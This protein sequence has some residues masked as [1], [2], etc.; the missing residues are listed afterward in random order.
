[1]DEI[2]TWIKKVYEKGYT[3][4]QILL[5][6]KANEEE[7]KE[8]LSAQQINNDWPELT[9]DD[10]RNIVNSYRAL[11]EAN[12]RIADERGLAVLANPNEDN[13][14]YAPYWE[15]SAWQK[16]RQKL[17]AN[18]FRDDVINTIEV[19]TLRTLRQLSRDTTESGPR[20][21]MV[22][23]NVQS[24]KTANM[25]ALMAMAA[26]W[27]WNMFIVLSGTI[28]SLRIQTEKRLVDDLD[29]RGCNLTWEAVTIRK[30]PE[31]F[32]N[33]A[34]NKDFEEA[35]PNRP[36]ATDGRHRYFTV[37]LKQKDRLKNL[38]YWLQE[39]PETQGK[40][41][42]LVIDDEADQAGINTAEADEERR[43]INRLIVNLVNGKKENGQPSI[44]RFK[45]MNYIG[46]TA[47]P[48][49]NVLNEAGEE[50]L[51]PR[52]FISSLAVSDEYFGPQRIFGNEDL[53]YDGLDIVREIKEEEIEDISNIH[54]GLL[55]LP[56]SLQES[57]CW[58]M[59]CVACQRYWGYNKPV[60]M[61]VHTSHKTEHHFNVADAISG[62]LN[63][64][65]SDEIIRACRMIWDEET[66][67]YKVNDFRRLFPDYRKGDNRE[68]EIKD[69]PAFKDLVPELQ[70]LLDSGITNIQVDGDQKFTYTNGIHMCVDNSSA[71]NINNGAQLRLVYPDRNNMPHP[72][73]AFIVVG[74]TTLSRGL[75]IEGLVSTFFLRRAQTADTLMQMGRWF[76]YRK[77]YEMLP[78]IWMSKRAWNQ[79]EYLSDMDQK[80]RDEISLM[81]AMGV[82]PI[83]YGPR[84]KNSPNLSLI[85]VVAKN[86]A[87][88]A[89]TADFDFTGHRKSVSVF[90]N[91]PDSL[92]KNLEVTKELLQ[93]LGEPSNDAKDSGN[94]FAKS[95]VLWEDVP[96]RIIK[97]LLE[98]YN[99]STRQKAF[100][101]IKPMIKW[102][103]KFTEEGIIGNWNVILAGRQTGNDW[104][105]S[106]SI[107]IKKNERSRKKQNRSDDAIVVATV[108]DPND[109]LS[110]I[111]MDTVDEATKLEIRNN[112]THK[113]NVINDLRSRAGLAKTP[114]LVIYIIDK[115]SM[116]RKEDSETRLPLKAPVDIAA[117]SI[118]IPGEKR[119]T[120]TAAAIRIDITETGYDLDD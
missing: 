4:D 87:Q 43:T 34:N 95:N 103:D 24:G 108:L 38:L 67:R 33:K 73:P 77:G 51:Y 10:W 114:Q 97:G 42:V 52:H 79:F 83:E 88:R 48:Y 101:D 26:D 37:C 1:M 76:G 117:F 68:V 46:Y 82:A 15:D 64:A 31:E 59:C 84:I 58:F 40:M 110:D 96:F 12:T 65:G 6:R 99:F 19:A 98:K 7:L 20:K 100:N 89:V 71:N 30:R 86:R 70:A 112:T 60:S 75:T 66:D 9:T 85:R 23:G 74:G 72:A 45:A 120:Q 36:L 28:E 109:I 118:N 78:R 50:S 116:P 107:S 18:G 56:N 5:A 94:P 53:D 81:A 21:G 69:Y 106:E 113:A 63:N 49:A 29:S 17:H 93:S 92:L 8:F 44:G 80:L 27:G 35:D 13:G 16:Y 105:V 104:S 57:L 55:Y 54:L 39:F 115:D 62:W 102:I 32:G 119:S 111:D 41:K 91:D 25:A 14:V 47:T 11:I 61:L 90:D 22:V 3:W 2:T